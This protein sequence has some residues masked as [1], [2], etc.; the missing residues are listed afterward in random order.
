MVQRPARVDGRGHG[1][2]ACESGDEA[3]GE[4]RRGGAHGRDRDSPGLDGRRRRFGLRPVE[5]V[6]DGEGDTGV[7]DQLSVAEPVLGADEGELTGAVECHIEDRRRDRQIRPPESKA[8]GAVRGEALCGCRATAAAISHSTAWSGS[9]VRPTTD[10]GP[11]LGLDP[12]P[13]LAWTPDWNLG[14]TSGWDT[15]VYSDTVVYPDFMID[16][17]T[18]RLTRRESQELTRRRLVESAAELFA[19]RGV[20]GTS[21]IAVAERAGFTRGAVHGNFSDK[22]ELAAAVVQFVVED[23]GPALGRALGSPG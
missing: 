23:L 10:L 22:D 13:G 20:R 18:P 17:P 8:I 15:Y 3:G 21:L 11:E 19:A 4:E 2:E 16:S 12:G 6:D 1:T 5:G 7:L 9:R 14:C